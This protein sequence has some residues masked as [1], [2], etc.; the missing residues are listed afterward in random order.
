[1]SRNFRIAFVLC[2][3][4]FLQPEG[5]FIQSANLSVTES[6]NPQ[7]EVKLSTN[8]KT[9]RVGD[10]LEVRV[11]VWN[12]GHEGLFISENIFNLCIASPLSI[13]LVGNSPVKVGRSQC[14]ADCVY[15]LNEDF[16]A[17]L[18][19]RWLVLPAGHFYGTVIRLDSMSFPELQ[20]IGRWCLKGK[21]GSTGLSSSACSQTLRSPEKT[22]KLP[23][24]AWEGMVDTNSIWVDV[25]RPHK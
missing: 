10:S 11:E 9:V 21:Y 22:D 13:V 18:V 16:T 25:V 19:E 24:R 12:I 1:M 15:K 7:L 14:A 20:T 17:A 4:F 8:T 6:G 23:Y 3:V 2:L 5:E